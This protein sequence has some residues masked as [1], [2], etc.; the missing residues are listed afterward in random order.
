LFVQAEKL[1]EKFKLEILLGIHSPTAVRKS[2]HF[3]GYGV[4]MKQFANETAIGKK[5]KTDLQLLSN[6]WLVGM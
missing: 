1:C 5:I 6:S 4:R 3:D 2:W